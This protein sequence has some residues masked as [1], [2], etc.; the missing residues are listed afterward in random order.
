[1]K[2]TLPA[3]VQLVLLKSQLLI[4]LQ[5]SYLMWLL[6]LRFVIVALLMKT[7]LPI[8]LALLRPQL[9]VLLLVPHLAS[10]VVLLRLILKPHHT[11]QHLPALTP[12]TLRIFESASL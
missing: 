11:R 12:Q 6:L 7:A 10:L 3:A 8:Q 5:P 4:L 2:P 9:L 1:M